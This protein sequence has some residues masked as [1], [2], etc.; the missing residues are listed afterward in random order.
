MDLGLT[1]KT[2]IVCASTSGLGR[3]C[4]EALLAEG[5]HVVINGRHPERTEAVARELGETWPG[6]VA[7]VTGD[8]TTIEGRA[9]LL[10]ARPN[11]DILI[12]N[13]AGPEPGAFSS[14]DEAAWLEALSANMVAPLMLIRAVLPAMRQRKFGRI[15]N[16]TSAM[17]TTPRPQMALSSGARAG[18]T[19]ALK[20][21]LLE[22]AQD[23]VTFNNLL[24][25]R[26]DT[27]RQVR[28]AKT[29]ME[30][31]GVTWDEARARQTKTIPAGRLG[32]PNE[33]GAT[34]AFVCSVQASYMTGMN[35]RLDGG[36]YPALL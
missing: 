35:I 26:F 19:A 29:A 2:A 14:F 11:P 10:A 33:F 36:S 18:L 22:V 3:A 20:G 34:C 24:P 6:R 30:R 12:N 27:D 8:V 16:I 31:D 4:A 1:G 15:V 7:G 21:L 5:V 25:E 28:M 17:V 13:N 9:A 23:N 32:R